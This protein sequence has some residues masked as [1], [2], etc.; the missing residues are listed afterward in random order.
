MTKRV[1]PPK[2][3]PFRWA[4]EVRRTT[5]D[6]AAGFPGRVY[7]GFP[8]S[9]RAGLSKYLTED[10]LIMHSVE[11]QELPAQLRALADHYERIK[12][13]D[14]DDALIIIGCRRGA[15]EEK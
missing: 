10:V 15:P 3:F 6:D 2:D 11:L 8:T 14:G 4:V 7:Y 9:I 13:V 12:V 1:P 5:A